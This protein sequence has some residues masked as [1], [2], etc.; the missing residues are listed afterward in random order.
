MTD[1]LERAAIYL[2]GY[3]FSLFGGGKGARSVT[4]TIPVGGHY[5]AELLGLVEA[6][7]YTTA[8]VVGK[9]LFI[10]V[11]LALKV[12]THWGKSDVKETRP[13]FN[14]W[15]IGTG[16]SLAFGVSAGMFIQ[17]ATEHRWWAALGPVIAVGVGTLLLIW[18]GRILERRD[19]QGPQPP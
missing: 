18:R 6:T 17:D 10:P 16:V 11:W 19:R 5:S 4:A 15:L 3:A 2:A 7:I 12:S 13:I 14:R 9:D 1:S 8:W